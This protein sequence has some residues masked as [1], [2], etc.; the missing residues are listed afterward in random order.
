MEYWT[1]L[2]VALV[3]RDRR[4]PI[5]IIGLRRNQGAFS[6]ANVVISFGL[7]RKLVNSASSMGL[8]RAMNQAIPDH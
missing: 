1:H 4:K 8:G 7:A 2:D 5:A 3:V 6:E